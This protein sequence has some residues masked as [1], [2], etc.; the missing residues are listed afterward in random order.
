MM[1]MGRNPRA[2]RMTTSADVV[3]EAYI[4][5]W[6]VGAVQIFYEARHIIFARLK[7]PGREEVFV[8]LG[9]ASLLFVVGIEGVSFTLALL[10]FLCRSFLFQ[11]RSYWF[12]NEG[13]SNSTGH[14]L[15]K[16]GWKGCDK[17]AIGN[18]AK[19][20]VEAQHSEVD[21]GDIGGVA[22]IFKEGLDTAVNEAQYFCKEFMVGLKTVIVLGF[23]ALNV[24]DHCLK[25]EI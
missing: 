25:T 18:T 4:G 12:A 7:T 6:H 9:F 2:E 24:I 10:F 16:G 5:L 15:A 14:G 19:D 1:N 21:F 11:L 8:D 20:R 3:V 13:R 22:A 17:S 23:E